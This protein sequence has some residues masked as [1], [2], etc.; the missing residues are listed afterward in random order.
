MKRL[1]S[2]LVRVNFHYF[3]TYVSMLLYLPMHEYYHIVGVLSGSLAEEQGVLI[4]FVVAA[5][6]GYIS[7]S[8]KP[9]GIVPKTSVSLVRAWVR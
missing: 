5:V 2:S 8:F 9:M 1:T 4:L 6:G 7:L 3:V